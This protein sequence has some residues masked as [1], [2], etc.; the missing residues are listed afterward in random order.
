MLS[1]SKHSALAFTRVLRQAQDDTPSLLLFLRLQL[2][3]LLSQGFPLL[4]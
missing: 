4:L 3:Y 2:H 1:L